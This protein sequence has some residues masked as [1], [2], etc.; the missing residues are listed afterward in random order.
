MNAE[1][2]TKHCPNTKLDDDNDGIP[3]ENDSGF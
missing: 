1:F 2:F 3:C